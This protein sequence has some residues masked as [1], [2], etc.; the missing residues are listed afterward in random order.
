VVVLGAVAAGAGV[1][2][3]LVTALAHR[4]PGDLP[5]FAKLGAPWLA[6]AFAVGAWSRDP[7]RGAVAG[8][9]ALVVATGAYYALMYAQGFYGRSPIGVWWVLVAVPGG[10]LFGGAGGAWRERRHWLPVALLLA[11][12]AGE[13][14]YFAL[15][16]D[17]PALAIG[18]LA[19]AAVLPLGLLTVRRDRLAAVGAAAVL[20][21]VGGLAVPIAWRALETIRHAANSSSLGD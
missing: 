14:L 7:V 16:G 8:A 19:V 2:L 1:A 6:A 20:A 18:E 4:A 21:L 17:A 10:M 5:F 3:G 13:G 9:L 12:L 11:A 15:R